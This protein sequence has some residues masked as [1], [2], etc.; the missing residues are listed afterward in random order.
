VVTAAL[1]SLQRSGAADKTRARLHGTL[2]GLLSYLVHQGLLTTDP[3]IAAGIARPKVGTRLPRYLDNAA[4]FAK[5]IQAA[6]TPDPAA[7]DPWPERELA[8][9]ALL[10]GTAARAGEVCSLTVGDLVLDAKSPTSASWARAASP[11]TAH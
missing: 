2:T 3:L 6:A 9:A 8:V 4:E 7:R 11:A 5:V 1:S 10:A